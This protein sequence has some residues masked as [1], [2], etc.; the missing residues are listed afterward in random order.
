LFL[1]PGPL[2]LDR[3]E[4]EQAIEVVMRGAE[5]VELVTDPPEYLRSPRF[6]T[7]LTRAQSLRAASDAVQHLQK[8]ARRG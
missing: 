5:T 2:L 7:V 4:P 1:K 3:G 6:D 8:A